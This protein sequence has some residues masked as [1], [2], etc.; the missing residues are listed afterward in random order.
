MKNQK[1]YS[2]EDKDIKEKRIKYTDKSISRPC[3][4]SVIG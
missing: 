4:Y 3:F 2:Q 1:T